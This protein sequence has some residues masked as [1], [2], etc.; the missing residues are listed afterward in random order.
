M[1]TWDLIVAIGTPIAVAALAGL[2]VLAKRRPAK[3]GRIEREVEQA[4]TDPAYKPYGADLLDR[5]VP[6]GPLPRVGEVDPTDYVARALAHVPCEAT[7]CSHRPWPGQ[8]CRTCDL[9]YPCRASGPLNAPRSHF[10]D[11]RRAF[12]RSW[13]ETG[14]WDS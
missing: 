5:P 12:Q 7:S 6:V 10:E 13:R 9:P 8:H 2:I 14:R 4:L 11:D 1:T 3:A